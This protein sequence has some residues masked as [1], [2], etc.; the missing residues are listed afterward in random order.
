MIRPSFF[1]PADVLQPERPDPD[2]LPDHWGRHPR[3]GAHP[4]GRRGPEG[5]LL[6][7]RDPEPPRPLQGGTDL[8]LRRAPGLLRQRGKVHRPLR[9]GA[10]ELRHAMHRALQVGVFKSTI[11]WNRLVFFLKIYL[12]VSFYGRC[13]I[14]RP[15]LEWGLFGECSIL[16]FGST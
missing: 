9:G 12:K 3:A 10:K 7:P 4:G 1:L 11:Y 8:A 6:H 16:F 13:S 15:D 5:G 2:S 14:V